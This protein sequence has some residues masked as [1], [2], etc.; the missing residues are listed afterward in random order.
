MA[1]CSKAGHDH[2]LATTNTHPTWTS[3]KWKQCWVHMRCTDESS[4]M[5][6]SRAT[7]APLDR[8]CTKNAGASH[9]PKLRFGLLDSRHGVTDLARAQKSRSPWWCWKLAQTSFNLI[10]C[11]ASGRR[12][13]SISAI[14]GE[15]S[16]KFQVPLLI[17]AIA[18]CTVH[19][20]RQAQVFSLCN[21]EVGSTRFY[22]WTLYKI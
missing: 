2:S 22:V 4:G 5:V 16:C 14:K 18:W 1:L 13:K 8:T 20:K 19:L 6:A 3:M 17:I 7:W 11:Q 9:S 21:R 15:R 10:G 12:S